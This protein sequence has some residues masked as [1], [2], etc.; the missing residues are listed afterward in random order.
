MDLDLVRNCF[1]FI[2]IELRFQKTPK[3]DVKSHD[4][5]G[6]LTS[7]PCETMR[8]ENHSPNKSIVSLA[9][10]QIV[11]SCWNHMSSNSFHSL[12]LRAQNSVIML[13]LLYCISGLIFEVVW[14]NYTTCTK[15]AADSGPLG[16]PFMNHLRILCSPNPTICLLE[17]Y[18][19]EQFCEKVIK[20]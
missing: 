16:M 9:L 6:K 7:T 13:H 11:Q 20:N 4:L 14:N 19:P 5:S 12:H 1:R 17:K 2:R 3:K 15:Y 18:N 10:W 8:S